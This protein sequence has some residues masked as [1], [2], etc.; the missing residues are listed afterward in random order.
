MFTI[1]RQSGY[2]E[3]YLSCPP[4]KAKLRDEEKVVDVFQWLFYKDQMRVSSVRPFILKDCDPSCPPQVFS[5]AMRKQQGGEYICPEG[6]VSFISTSTLLTYLHNIGNFVR[7]LHDFDPRL[8]DVGE[9]LGFVWQL[10]R[11]VS[12]HKHSLQ[13][14]PQVLDDQPVLNDLCGTSQLVRPVLDLGFERSIVS[15][16]NC[17]GEKFFLAS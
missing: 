10:L 15:E 17:K 13:V 3:S 1:L 2:T 16:I 9:P 14:D 5:S 11:D 12:P 6:A 8:V 4:W 7:S